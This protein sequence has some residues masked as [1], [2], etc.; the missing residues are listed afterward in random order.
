MT[1]FAWNQTGPGSRFQSEFLHRARRNDRNRSER[2]IE[3]IK[4]RSCATPLAAAMKRSFSII[5]LAL[6]CSASA[7]AQKSPYATG[8]DFAKYAMRLRESALLKMEPQVFIPT[9]GRMTASGKHPW[10]TN[11]VTTVFW[12]GERPTTNNPVPNHTSSWDPEWMQ[13]FGGFDSP[14]PSARKNY[15]PASFIPRQNPFYIALPY[16]DVT[17]GTTKPEARQVIPWYKDEFVKEG[18]SICR[19]RWVAVRKGNR[20]CYAQ[21]SDCGPFRTDHFEYVFGNDRPKPNLNRGAGLDVSP[22]V[23]DFLR[24]SST[25]VT[26]W[27][28][29][30]VREVPA[31]PWAIYGTNNTVAKNAQKNVQ[32]VVSNKP[33]VGSKVETGSPTVITK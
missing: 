1:A 7:F 21:W 23:R 10:K 22:A 9:T 17:R 12:V 4:I 11:I 24:L 28:F 29:V 31:G 15:L 19:D 5:V 32:S 2:R 25:D 26:D 14:D 13:N 3:L 27:K 20:V 16:N 30:E 33:A 8:T 18:Q 6:L